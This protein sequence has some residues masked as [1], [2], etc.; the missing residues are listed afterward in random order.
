[1]KQKIRKIISNRDLAKIVGVGESYISQVL[2]GR[3]KSISKMTAY[4]ICKAISPDLEI[5]DL[6][7][8]FE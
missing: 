4:S 8:I 3:R 1:M 6:F 7:D 2:N 5:S